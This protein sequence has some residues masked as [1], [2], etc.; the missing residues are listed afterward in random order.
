MNNDLWDVSR[1]QEENTRIKINYDALD[2][3]NKRLIQQVMGL[4][5]ENKKLWERHNEEHEQIC[6][7]I[8]YMEEYNEFVV[9]D[10]DIKSLILKEEYKK[11]I[12]ILK[13]ENIDTH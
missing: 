2:E 3:M 5:T 12:D 8:K 4:E 11:I 9:P 13:G 6:K 1:V 10:A 7:A